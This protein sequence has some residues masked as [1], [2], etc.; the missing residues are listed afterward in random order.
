LK[1]CTTILFLV[2]N[3]AVSHRVNAESWPLPS[4]PDTAN[5]GKYCSRT[6]SLLNS[7]TPGHRKEVKILVYG[8]SISEQ[9]W[10]LEVKRSVKERFPDAD[11]IM[12]NKAIGGFS[13]QYLF[14]TVEMDVSSFYPDLVLLHIYGNSADY[15]K[16]L[17]TIRSRTTSEIAIMTDHYIGYNKW[18][19]TMSYFILPSLA[20]KYKCDIINIRDPWKTYLRDN[21]LEPND[22][23]KDGIHL[24]DYG[25]FVMAELVKPLFMYKSKFP[26]DPL[27]LETETSVK[28][29]PMFRNDTLFLPFEGN[30]VDLVY[31]PEL[32]KTRDTVSITV[33]GQKPSSFQ[34]TY[35]MTRPYSN[36]GKSW[37]WDLPAMICVGHSVPWI[38]EEWSLLFTKAKPPFKDFSFRISGSVTGADGYGRGTKDFISKSGRVQISGDDAENGGDWHLGRSFRVLKTTVRKGDLILWKTYSASIDKLIMAPEDYATG[39]KIVS[40]FQG[41]PPGQHTLAISGKNLDPSVVKEFKIYKPL[42]P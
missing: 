8:Q 31:F 18:S 37:P 32:L 22:L 5:L 36:N 25:N 34:G 23:L 41:L 9:E 19:D 40:L 33:D 39:G 30:R 12:E 16:V 42:L 2:L 28:A 1:V 3:A 6:L 27:K 4:L 14:K 35:Y 21:R 29:D 13:T 38:N 20:E 7:S 24:N 15:E 11:L 26:S 17:K 10:W